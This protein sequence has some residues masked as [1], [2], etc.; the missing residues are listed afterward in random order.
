[1][2]TSTTIVDQ[3]TIGQHGI[4]Y[5]REQRQII[6]N[7]TVIMQQPHRSTLTP[8]SSLTD[9]PAQVAAIA[10]VVW[11]PDVIAAFQQLQQG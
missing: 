4:I 5:Y 11:T 1:M 3:I 9:V 6:E 2:L 8:G 10:A 7:G